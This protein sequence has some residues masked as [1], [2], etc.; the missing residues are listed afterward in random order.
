MKK[1]LMT[2]ALLPLIGLMSLIPAAAQDDKAIEVLPTMESVSAAPNRIWVGTFQIVW[3][4]TMNEVVKKP[5]KFVRYSSMLAKELNKQRFKKE[6]I[7]DNSY[8]TTYGIVS[9]ELKDKIVNAIKEK[10]NETSDITDMFDWTYQPNKIFIYAML[11]K[12]FKFLEPFD[13]GRKLI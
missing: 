6:Y 8:Y 4:E 12:D 10:F 7:S 5:V 1:F 2:L 11:K 13:K 3:N 9:P